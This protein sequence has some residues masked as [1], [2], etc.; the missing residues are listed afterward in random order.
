MNFAFDAV[1]DCGM[2]RLGR[3]GMA[4]FVG[5]KLRRQVAGC[6]AVVVR[7][8]RK[9]LTIHENSELS[10]NL[11]CSKSLNFSNFLNCLKN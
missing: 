8:V 1:G 10:D 9:I 3:S 7:I 5:K 11:N 2:L 6:L 4:Q